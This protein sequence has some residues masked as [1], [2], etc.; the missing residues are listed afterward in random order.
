MPKFIVIDTF[1]FG[2]SIR[3][4]GALL[5]ISKADLEAEKAKGKKKI[6]K[7]DGSLVETK[8]WL[9]G[10][11]NHCEPEDDA[12]AEV[13]SVKLDPKKTEEDIASETQDRIDEIYKEMDELGIAYDRRWKLP[14][15]ENELVKAKKIRGE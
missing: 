7:A 1:L 4:A 14:K 8:T 3:R 2:G 10:I 9:S 6:K 15:L 13:L 12:A 5:T 11:L